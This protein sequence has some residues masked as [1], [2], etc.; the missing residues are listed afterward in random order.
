MTYQK[1]PIC[2]GSGMIPEPYA[3]T[4]SFHVKC[5]TCKGARIISSMTGLPPERVVMEV[6]EREAEARKKDKE[7]MKQ[8]IEALKK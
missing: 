1:C 5:P 6:E 3:V 4:T 8:I 2:D 7:F